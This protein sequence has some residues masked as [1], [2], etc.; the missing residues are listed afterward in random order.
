M[1][2]IVALFLL[3]PLSPVPLCA[4]EK[5]D[6]QER[7]RALEERIHALE[8]EVQAL[9]AAQA[10]TAAPA[11]KAPSGAAPAMVQAPVGGQ[12]GGPSVQLPVYGGA[13]GA[14]KALN[15]DI[16][17]I[18]DFIGSVGR[19]PVRPVPAL[20]MHESELS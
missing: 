10:A 2:A 1:K 7:L 5:D 6:T 12:Q 20:E 16:S 14:A 3:L 19:S 13:S 17:I 18:G 9:K 11:L 8:A 15:P 4:Q